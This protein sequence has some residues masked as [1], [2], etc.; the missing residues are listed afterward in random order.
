[1]IIQLVLVV[2]WDLNLGLCFLNCIFCALFV[3]FIF[4]PDPVCHFDLDCVFRML[5]VCVCVRERER[6]REGMCTYR[7]QDREGDR[8]EE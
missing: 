1:M 6:E 8:E 7:K 4:Q 5:C 2:D 3:E